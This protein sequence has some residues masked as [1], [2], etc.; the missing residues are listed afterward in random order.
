M[1]NP[2]SFLVMATATSDMVMEQKELVGLFEVL[3]SLVEDST[4]AET[5][6][7]P[8]TDTPWPGVTCELGEDL[9]FHVTKIHIGPDILTPPCKVS[10]KLSPA[11]VKLPYL[12]T[13]SLF[14]CFAGSP[15]SLSPSLLGSLSSLEHLALV[16][17]PSL[18]GEIPPSLTK[19]SSL[20]ILCLSQNNLNGKIPKEIDGLVSLEQLDLSYNSLRGS[21]PVEI[22]G[23]RGLTIL[24]LSWNGLQGQVPFSLGQLEFLQKI[25]LSSNHLQGNVPSNLGALKRLVLLDMS[26]NSLSGPIPENLTG[27][28][29]LEY[30]MINDN[31]INTG[32]P[33]FIGALKKLKVIGFSRCGLVGPILPS[34][35]KLKNLTALSLENNSLNGTVPPDLGTL[36]NLDQLNLSQN[37]L[38]GELLLS[39]AFMNRLGKRLDVT[40][41]SGLC[42]RYNVSATFEQEPSC[43]VTSVPPPG[44]N[45]KSWVEEH[46]NGDWENQNMKPA[47]YHGNTS[48]NTPRLDQKVVFLSF[49]VW[50]L[51]L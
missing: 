24:D 38:S 35:S 9:I 13:L 4:W 2:L 11:L 10:A 5:H 36:P 50:F 42:I 45:N 7:L 44:S 43:V 26:H 32:I 8:C 6:P 47:W 39:E 29:Q 34:F 51:S 14:K 17:N 48:P 3:G 46:P 23:L 18:F 30:L 12:K 40:G 33:L 1:W 37:Q 16:S 27:L 22:G 41:N 15:V 28:D 49:V 21:L 19:V 31:P 20:R 25:D